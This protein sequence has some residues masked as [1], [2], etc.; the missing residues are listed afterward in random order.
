[1]A[2]QMGEAFAFDRG[3]L[4]LLDGVQLTATGPQLEEIVAAQSDM[5]ADALVP[6]GAI[7][8]LPLGFGH[9]ETPCSSRRSGKPL[10]G[11]RRW[12]GFPELDAEGR[13]QLD[14]QRPFAG[15]DEACQPERSAESETENKDPVQSSIGRSRHHCP[16]EIQH[17]VVQQI[18][19]ERHSGEPANQPFEPVSRHR[20]LHIGETNDKKRDEGAEDEIVCRE[21]RR[22]PSAARAPKQ[23]LTTEGL[24][25]DEAGQAH[26]YQRSPQLTRKP[27]PPSPYC[28]PHQPHRKKEQNSW[29]GQQRRDNE[30]RYP[31]APPEKYGGC[32]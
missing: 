26:R 12:R 20:E 8:A 18:E 16:E 10:R 2:L 24:E 22:Q 3:Q 17:R 5:N 21:V 30:D 23:S 27:C 9:G 7:G 13:T 19:P 15:L 29:S 25:R 6:V 4:R 28:N 14:L 32:K 31:W 1:M 11:G